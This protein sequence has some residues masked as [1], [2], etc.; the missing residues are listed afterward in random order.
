MIDLI[1]TDVYYELYYQ[2]IIKELEYDDFYNQA[3]QKET[4][5]QNGNDY[6]GYKNDFKANIF[7]GRTNKLSFKLCHDYCSECYEL[8]NSINSQKC[9]SCLPDYS[10]DYWNYFNKT[11][12]SNC[13]PEYE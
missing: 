5:A 8:G 11:F 10:Y 9:E 7:Y 2:G 12:K 4:H 6:N 3:H 1:K 13:V